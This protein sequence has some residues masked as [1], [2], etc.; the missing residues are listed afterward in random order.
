[1]LHLS[2]WENKLDNLIDIDLLWF[3]DGS[4]IKVVLYKID[5]TAMWSVPKCKQSSFIDHYLRI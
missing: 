4:V 5:V 2:R 3:G 1:M